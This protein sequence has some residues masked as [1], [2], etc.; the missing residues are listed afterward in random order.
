MTATSFFTQHLLIETGNTSFVYARYRVWK[1][2]NE[3]NIEV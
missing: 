3:S 2:K 1:H